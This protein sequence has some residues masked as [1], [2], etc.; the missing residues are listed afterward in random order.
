N[1]VVDASADIELIF[2]SVG[3][4]IAVGSFRAVQ[5][6]R[7]LVIDVLTTFRHVRS[8]YSFQTRIQISC[9]P[10]AEFSPGLYLA[11]LRTS[12]S[13]VDIRHAVVEPDN[14]VLVPPFHTLVAVDAY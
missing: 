3:D 7:V 9:V 11:E 2:E 6:N 4:L 12:D 1:R 8:N 10:P 13:G 5:T 14:F